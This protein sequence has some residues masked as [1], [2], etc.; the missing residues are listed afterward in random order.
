MRRLV[1]GDIHGYLNALKQVLERSGW[2]EDDL[3][4]GIGDYVDGWSQSSQVIEFISHLKNFVGVRGN[5]DDWGLKWLQTRKQPDIWTSQGGKATINSYREHLDW[6]DSH[7][8]FLE[9]LP[10]YLILDNMAFI[11]GG[12][13]NSK[14]LNHLDAVS[15]FDL[16]WDRDLYSNA[17]LAKHR[18]DS[19]SIKPFDKVFVGHTST[20]TKGF[21]DE[22][23][24]PFTYR[25]FWNIDQGGGW[26]GKLTIVDID[27][28]EYW[29]SDFVKDLHK[30]EVERR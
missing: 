11:H 3:L 5:H 8:E 18:K 4:I 29:Q 19:F 22:K 23:Y 1:V 28:N 16:T 20:T 21:G 17:F 27:T 13:V 6:I 12:C 30:S 9:S 7:R 2:T 24:L 15:S 14:M 26:E 10:Y 25:G